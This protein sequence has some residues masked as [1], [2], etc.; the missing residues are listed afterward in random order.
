MQRT[1]IDI[2]SIIRQCALVVYETTRIGSVYRT[3]YL[4]NIERRRDYHADQVQWK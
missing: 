1:C 4:L 3:G 2:A